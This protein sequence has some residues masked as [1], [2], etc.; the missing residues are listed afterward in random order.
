[1]SAWTVRALRKALRPLVADKRGMV[2]HSHGALYRSN[3]ALD[4]S[5]FICQLP[6]LGFLGRI[7]RQFRSVDRVLRISPSHAMIMDGG[8]FIARRSE[9]WCCDLRTGRLTLDFHI[10]DGRRALEFSCIE[11]PGGDS[12]L[13]FGEYFDNPHRG[14]VRIWGRS[15]QRGTWTV[16]AE[17]PAGEIEHIHAVTAI[18]DRVWVLCGDF[19][20]S[21]SIWTSDSG[22][23]SITP[24]LRGRQA[25]RAAWI[26]K[27][28]GRLLYATDTQLE[29]NHVFELLEEGGG[30]GIREIASID[31]SSIY[32]GRGPGCLFF[33]TTVESGMPSGNLLLDMLDSRRGPGILSERAKIMMID[34]R[35][36]PEELFSAA[37]D[38]LPFRLA[39][40][41]TFTF[42]SGEMPEDITVAYGTAV[43]GFDDTC[44]VFSR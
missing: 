19:E 2:C 16:L 20:H 36:Q 41:G 25:Y 11:Q 14:L 1:M 10:P 42:P 30:G 7:G 34:A 39:Q 31:G 18:G 33:S 29:T 35:G 21:A 3:Y 24:V 26:A 5:E 22:F 12:L 4:R 32:S 23:S 9:I 43:R 15:N 17:I 8:L 6:P 40:F 44:L 37:K 28:G 27:V 13:V 38:A